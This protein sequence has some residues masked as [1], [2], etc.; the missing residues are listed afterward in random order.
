MASSIPQRLI[1]PALGGPDTSRA[2][3]RQLSASACCA[4]RTARTARTS[5]TRLRDDP[6]TKGRLSASLAPMVALG[7]DCPVVGGGGYTG[8]E[9]NLY[10]HRDRR[11]PAVAPARFKW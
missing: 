4:W 8:F 5:A 6:A 3:L 7:G 1:E 10:P 9:H 11:R 2:R